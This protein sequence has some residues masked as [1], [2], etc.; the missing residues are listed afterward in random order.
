MAE[1]TEIGTAYL[2]IVPSAAGFGAKLEQQITGEAGKVGTQAGAALGTG[3]TTSASGIVKGL[4]GVLAAAGT[5]KFL[6]GAVAEAED[7]ARVGRLTEAVIKSTGGA[8]G[9]TADQVESLAGKLSKV[10]AVDDE[11]IQGAENILLTFT[12]VSGQVFP[13][14]T[15]AALDMS[16]ALGTDLQGATIQ[17]GKALNDPVAGMTALTRSGVSFTESQKE[18]I[19]TLQ[20]SGDLLGAQKIILGEVNRE[21]GGA[22]AAGAT[23]TAQLGVAIGNLKESLG[24]ALLPAVNVTADGLAALVG[25][26]G[27]LPGPVQAVS[28]GLV[29]LAGGALAASLAVGLFVPKVRAAKAELLEM[30]VAGRTAAGSIGLIGKAGLVVGTLFAVTTG[31]KALDAAIQDTDGSVKKLSRS[32]DEELGRQFDELGSKQNIVRSALSLFFPS[33]TQDEERGELFAKILDDGNFALA[34]RILIAQRG[35]PIHAALQKAYDDE[36]AAVRSLNKDQGL[37]NA[38][39]G[40]TGDVLDATTPKVRDYAAE[41]EDLSGRLQDVIQSDFSSQLAGNLSSALNPL[42]LFVVGAGTKID[43]LKGAV[44]SASG[45]LTAA[46]AELAKLEGATTGT[47]GDIAR[48]RGGAGD[49]DAA[50]AAV[51]DAAARLTETQGA[52]REATKSPLAA[53]EDNLTSNLASVTAWLGNLDKISEGGHESLARHLTSLGPQ[54][55][56]AVAEAVGVSPKQLD[57]LEGLFNQAD[58]KIKDAASGGFELGLAQKANPGK[59]LADVIVDAYDKS[60]APGIT[61]AT[62]RALEVAT[63]IITGRELGAHLPSDVAGEPGPGEA[64]RPPAPYPVILGPAVPPIYGPAVPQIAAQVP[65]GGITIQ[66]TV[67]AQTDASPHE[68]AAEVGDHLAWRLGPAVATPLG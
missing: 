22:A 56:D 16:A 27:E 7:A 43:E 15:K 28:G 37:S 25:V 21:F 38:I 9:V 14:A 8:A 26:V 12:R 60:L 44:T 34:E 5:W 3:L 13:A 57:K 39:L 66:T 19:K 49:L 55:A 35:T 54:A 42:E 50:R 53:I 41:W 2:S 33:A 68:I 46:R 62:I 52:L 67:N 32:A 61:D 47:A 23:S 24:T 29:V 17:L 31:M 63:G 65:A 51:A 10:A 6:Q 40:Q 45:D 11:V 59:T 64:R 36:L 58:A 48:L 18:Q 20:A 4:G 1:G 30:G